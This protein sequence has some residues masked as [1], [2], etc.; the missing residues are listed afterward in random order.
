MEKQVNWPH[1]VDA[2]RASESDDDE[3]MVGWH[4]EDELPEGYP[5]DLEFARSRVDGVRMFP[6]HVCEFVKA[7]DGGTYVCRCGAWR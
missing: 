3:E 7:L 6:P 4:Y 1:L 5:Y 2:A